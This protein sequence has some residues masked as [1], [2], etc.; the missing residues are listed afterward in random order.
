[1]AKRERVRVM[2]QKKFISSDSVDTHI[3]FYTVKDNVE[4]TTTAP[5]EKARFTSLDSAMEYLARVYEPM[6]PG[7]YE[8][9]AAGLM[10]T[11][12]TKTH[13]YVIEEIE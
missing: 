9:S 2:Y 6:P 7:S 11:D 4:G 13:Q 10:Q 1:M 3:I 8:L 12:G 5:E